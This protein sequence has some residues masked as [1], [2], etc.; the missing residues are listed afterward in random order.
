MGGSIVVMEERDYEA[1]LAG[2]G[3]AGGETQ[4][5]GEELFAA[6]TCN[7]CHRPDSNLQGPYLQGVFGKEEALAD[8]GTVVVDENYLRESILDPAAK[9]VQGYQPLMPTYKGQLS[10]EE[11]L[12]L[13][14]YIKSLGDDQSTTETSDAA[15]SEAAS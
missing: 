1:W 11:L 8:G 3:G 6:K 4:L 7:T 5:S 12:Q 15:G 2:Q 10:E 9:V 13:I 14:I